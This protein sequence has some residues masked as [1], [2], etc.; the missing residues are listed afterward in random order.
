MALTIRFRIHNITHDYHKICILADNLEEKAERWFTEYYTSNNIST[1]NYDQ[2]IFDFQKYFTRKIDSSDVSRKLVTINQ[3][4]N[5]DRYIKE[6]KQ[7]KNLLTKDT[8]S[9]IYTTLKTRP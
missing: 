1:I 8:T 9:V 5:I 2:S 6:F 4:S 3:R 7:Y